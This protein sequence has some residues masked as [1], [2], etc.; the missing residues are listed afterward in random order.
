MSRTSLSVAKPIT[1]RKAVAN[2]L[3]RPVILES[4]VLFVKKTTLTEAI[5]AADQS[6]ETYSEMLRDFEK[7]SRSSLY[8]VLARVYTVH[9]ILL[10]DEEKLRRFLAGRQV[11]RAKHQRI[12]GREIVVAF[13][14]GI[15][16]SRISTYAGALVEADNE[17]I[18][19]KDFPAWI[20]RTGVSK[21]YR[22]YLRGNRSTV[23][24][25]K[26]ARERTRLAREYIDACP[27]DILAGLMG[28][29]E[30]IAD[31]RPDGS[32]R[33]LAITNINYKAIET[34]LANLMRARPVTRRAA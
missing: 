34:K 17:K 29:V 22:T 4:E 6:V 23:A 11:R 3:S 26:I 9:S 13:L 2:N 10:R 15:E 21:A 7:R 31:I 33:P 25:I 12:P 30:L 16:R 28:L 20:A 27:R 24:R 32:I 19:P 1:N 8:A 18:A 14:G 5:R